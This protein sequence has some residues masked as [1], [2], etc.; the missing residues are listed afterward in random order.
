ML[1]G[2]NMRGLKIPGTQEKLIANLFADFHEE[3]LRERKLRHWDQ[4]RLMNFMW[5]RKHSLVNAE[6]MY[7]P[8]TESGRA[9]LD[10]WK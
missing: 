2:S 9:L 8:Q 3:V 7:R 10:L 6:T 4:K 5:A 1:R